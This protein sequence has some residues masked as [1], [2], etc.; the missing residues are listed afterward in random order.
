VQI[1]PESLVLGERAGPT[2]TST[3]SVDAGE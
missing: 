2:A 1:E 3:R